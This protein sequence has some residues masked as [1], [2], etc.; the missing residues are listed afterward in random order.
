MLY[1]LQENH[2][3]KKQNRMSLLL[4]RHFIGIGRGWTFSGIGIQ[5]DMVS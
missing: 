4:G 5:Y 1:L 2:E 3:T